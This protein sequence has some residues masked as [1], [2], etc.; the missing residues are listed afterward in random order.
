MCACNAVESMTTGNSVTDSTWM[1]ADSG[2]RATPPS[3]G[4]Q[5]FDFGA[6]FNGELPKKLLIMLVGAAV[7]SACMSFCL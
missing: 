6:F 4:N 2:I 1:Q 5:K 3:Q 7:I